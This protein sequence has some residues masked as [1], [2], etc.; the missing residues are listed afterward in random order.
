MDVTSNALLD[1]QA[2]YR[3]S[4]ARSKKGHLTP[5]GSAIAFSIC[6]CHACLRANRT[7]EAQRWC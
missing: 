5:F 4:Q 2:A 6:I 3:N 1:T 7:L